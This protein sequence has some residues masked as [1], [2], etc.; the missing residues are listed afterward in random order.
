VFH[1]LTGDDRTHL[2]SERR[3]PL[4]QQAALLLQGAL[5]LGQARHRGVGGGHVGG[6]GR[7][8]CG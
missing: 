8:A 1:G 7:A 2:G 3:H 4:L 5:A 6:Q